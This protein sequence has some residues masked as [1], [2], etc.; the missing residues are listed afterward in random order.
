MSEKTHVAREKITARHLLTALGIL[1]L[2][3]GAF[4]WQLWAFSQRNAGSRPESEPANAPENAP[5]NAP[6]GTHWHEANPEV[7]LAVAKSIRG[8]LAALQ[9][10]DYVNGLQYHTQAVRQQF[11]TPQEY[12]E[13][14]EQNYAYVA[15]F[16]RATFWFVNTDK[17]RHFANAGLTIQSSNGNSQEAVFQL[18]KQ[19]N[20]WLISAI[21]KRP[22][23]S[24]K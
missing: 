24:V 7:R 5:E 8:Q 23:H 12:Q 20:Q 21:A 10:G 6:P 1:L 15:H 14:I 13:L 4:G 22:P 11:S 19:N 17:T 18:A 2:T 16:K 9:K 3:F